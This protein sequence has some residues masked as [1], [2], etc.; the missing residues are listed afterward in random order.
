[1]RIGAPH[2]LMRWLSE[3]TTA[4][5]R[6]PFDGAINDLVTAYRHCI[7]CGMTFNSD[8]SYEKLAKQYHI[9]KNVLNLKQGRLS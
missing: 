1:M 2:S 8:A 4:L 3:N 9:V 7:D 6:E 5:E